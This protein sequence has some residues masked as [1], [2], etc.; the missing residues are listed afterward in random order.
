MMDSL[1]FR[2]VTRPVSASKFFHFPE[3]LLTQTFSFMG[4]NDISNPLHLF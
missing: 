2:A 4:R 1:A 3:N